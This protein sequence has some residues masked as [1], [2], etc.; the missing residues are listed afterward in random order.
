[1]LKGWAL[2]L[3]PIQKKRKNMLQT[4]NVKNYMRQCEKLHEAKAMQNVHFVLDHSTSEKSNGAVCV[5]RASACVS[6][7]SIIS[8]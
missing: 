4:T 3:G 7:Y 2:L 1:M 6:L 5:L 8:L